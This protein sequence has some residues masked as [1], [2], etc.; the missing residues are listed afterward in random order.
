MF[1]VWF[2]CAICTD[3]KTDRATPF[4]V[5]P[6]PCRKCSTVVPFCVCSRFFAL[7]KFARTYFRYCAQTQSLLKMRFVWSTDNLLFC[8]QP[9]RFVVDSLPSKINSNILWNFIAFCSNSNNNKD[10]FFLP[11]LCSHDWI[12]SFENDHLE[13]PTTTTFHRNHTVPSL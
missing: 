4:L 1:S 8:G 5:K 6:L 12:Y 2:E 7:Y 9:K 11:M 10:P 3:Q 13:R